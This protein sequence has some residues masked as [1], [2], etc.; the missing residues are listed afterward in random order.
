M[1]LEREKQ[2]VKKQI[3]KK[4]VQKSHIIHLKLN[5]QHGLVF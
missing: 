2:G 3:R 1:A 5:E 4:K